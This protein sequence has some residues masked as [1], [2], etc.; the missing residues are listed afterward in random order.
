MVSDGPPNATAFIVLKPE[1]RGG[2]TDQQIIDWCRGEMAVYKAPRQVRFVEAL[3][4]TASGKIL[5]RALREQAR[6]SQC[7]SDGG[8]A[9]GVRRAGRRPGP[10]SSGRDRGRGRIPPA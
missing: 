7:A 3:P 9:E 2:V 5:K 10:A 6:A 4:K 1:A 8:W